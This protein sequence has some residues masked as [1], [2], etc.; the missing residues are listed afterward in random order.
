MHLLDYCCKRVSTHPEVRMLRFCLVGS[1]VGNLERRKMGKVI[2]WLHNVTFSVRSERELIKVDWENL[3]LHSNEIVRATKKW[4]SGFIEIN[5]L[6]MCLAGGCDRKFWER[7]ILDAGSVNAPPL[8]QKHP[9]CREE[10][11][12]HAAHLLKHNR[13]GN[14]EKGRS[15]FHRFTVAKLRHFMSVLTTALVENTLKGHRLVIT[16]ASSSTSSSFVC[17]SS[18]FFWFSLRSFRNEMQMK[19]W[20]GYWVWIWNDRLEWRPLLIRLTGFF[21]ESL[22]IK[23]YNWVDQSTDLNA[24][25]TVAFGLI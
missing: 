12:T 20:N 5:S 23:R 24:F 17:F 6:C 15:K 2:S 7:N 1:A 8:E 22:N 11:K 4:E 9:R 14:A 13:Q 10:S 18:I 16:E 21:F 25:P 3:L 19:S